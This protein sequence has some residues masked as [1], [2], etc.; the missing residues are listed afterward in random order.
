MDQNLQIVALAG[1][2]GGAKLAD[3]LAR[4]LPSE[5]LKII[6]NTGDDFEYCGLYICPDIDTMVYTLAGIANPTTGWGRADESWRVHEE[7]IR[8]GSEAW[9]RLGDLDLAWHLERTRRKHSGESLEAITTWQT[10]AFGVKPGVLPMCNEPV[11]TKVITRG[12]K[13]LDFQEYFVRLQCEPEVSGFV[14]HNA[15]TAKPLLAAIEAI[16]AADLIVIC[17]SNPWVSIG[18]ILAIPGYKE[19]LTGKTIA[20]VSPIVSGKT[21]KGPAA[22]MYQEM[23]ITPSAEAVAN[24]YHELISHFIIDTEDAACA[25]RIKSRWGIMTVDTNTIMRSASDRETLARFVISF[26]LGINR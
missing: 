17:P 18:P 20:A 5:Q 13:I 2:V 24:T 15:E 4:V 10:R 23:G 21:I 1:G 19:A 8:L 16:R 11:Q 22:K 14:F 25:N 6:V 26:A 9:F 7:R 3:G 12:Q